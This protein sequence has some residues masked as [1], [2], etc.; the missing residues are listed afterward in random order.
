MIAVSTVISAIALNL[1]LAGVGPAAAPALNPPVPVRAEHG[2][3]PR[4]S[5]ELDSGAVFFGEE[6]FGSGWKYGGG[7]FFRTGRR[8]GVEVLLEKSGVPMEAGAAGLPGSGRMSMTSLLLDGQLYMFDNGRVLPYALAGIGFIFIGYSPDVPAAG[9][10]MDFVD[11]LALQIGGGVVYRVAGGL[12][13][14]G[15]ARY[16]LVKT[17]IEELPATD[18]RR[19]DDPYAQNMLHLYGLELAFGLRFS[20]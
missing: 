15:K 5:V 9:P 13:I 14:S 1:A 16:N 12:S 4:L 3:L 18:P 8:T 7:V 10:E 11:R 19:D 20:F 6:G 2:R 17:W